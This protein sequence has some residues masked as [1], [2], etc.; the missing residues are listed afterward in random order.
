MAQI[1]KANFWEMRSIAEA[2]V[3]AQ[4]ISSVQ[5]GAYAGR[6][7]H[8]CLVPCAARNLTFMILPGSMREQLFDDDLGQPNSAI[9]AFRLCRNQF[10][11]ALLGSLE[12]DPLQ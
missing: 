5:P 7:H 12:L 8:F 4:H 3:L 6:E 11:R 1:M 9:A 2:V 10:Q